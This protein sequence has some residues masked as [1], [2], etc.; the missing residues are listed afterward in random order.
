M[1]NSIL[2]EIAGP[3][4]AL[5]IVAL[6]V[7]ATT[8]NFFDAGNARNLILQVSIVAIVA[9]EPEIASRPSCP[10][11]T[12]NAGGSSASNWAAISI[13]AVVGHSL[14]SIKDFDCLIFY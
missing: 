13:I 10:C 11:H 3:L 14:C 7:A 5:L 12:R 4:A 2:R 6:L 8:Q 1:K 9:G